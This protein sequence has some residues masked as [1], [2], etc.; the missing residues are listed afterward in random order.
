MMLAVSA[1]VEILILIGRSPWF[2]ET[3]GATNQ[4]LLSI[5]A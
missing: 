4:K 3:S 2:E 1:M 5:C